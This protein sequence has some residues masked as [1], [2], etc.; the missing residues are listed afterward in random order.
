MNSQRLRGIVACATAISLL[1]ACGGG[2]GLEITEAWA[3]TSPSMADAGAAYMQITNGSDT[4]DALVG[5]AVD[6][7]VA[8]TVEIHETVTMEPDTTM[9][10]MEDEAMEDD[11]VEDGE[12][13]GMMTMQPV[14]RIVVPAGET[15]SLQPGGYHL[16]FLGLESPLAAG[17]SIDITLTF[18]EAGEKTVTAEVRDNAP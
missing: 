8:A 2:G 12:M 17:D 7:S 11:D 5:V 9:G 14:E 1:A 15:V 16:M 4:D 13:G 3:R 6:P 18:E 10:E